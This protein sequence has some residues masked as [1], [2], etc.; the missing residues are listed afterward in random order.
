MVDREAFEE[1][2]KCTFV[3]QK[4]NGIKVMPQKLRSRDN[5]LLSG[6]KEADD[7]HFK[8]WVKSRGF[9]LM[10]YPVLGVKKVLCQLAKNKAL[11]CN[12]VCTCGN[13]FPQDENDPT[14]LGSFCH[15]T[16]VEHFY[17]IQRIHPQECGHMGYKKTL[18]EV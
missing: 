4:K 6:S 5:R 11:Q 14:L 7:T 8:F 2:V 17:D 18:A 15:V 10:D 16:Y 3:D 12:S 9:C 1:H 13:T